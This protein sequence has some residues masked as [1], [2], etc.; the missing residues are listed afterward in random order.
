METDVANN[1]YTQ[2]I[3]RLSQVLELGETKLSGDSI[4]MCCPIHYENNPSFGI[5]AVNGAFHC[6]ACG[7]KGHISKFPYYLRSNI[8]AEETDSILDFEVTAKIDTVSYSAK[9]PGGEIGSIRNRLAD[10]SLSKYT[11]RELL[12]QIITGH[13]V[14]LSGAKNNS[15]WQGQ[16]VVMIDID[17]DCQATMDD[18]IEYATSVGLEPSFAYH[19]YT[20][21]EDVC[22]CRL[23]YV[24]KEPI[25]D[26]K[27]YLDILKR[28]IK[29]FKCYSVDP[30]CADLCRMFYGTMNTEVYVSNSV[31]YH[32][33]TAEQINEVESI[34]GTSSKSSCATS[35]NSEDNEFFDGKIF[36]HH[37]FGQYMIDNYYI[38]R[39]NGNQLHI[40][41]GRYLCE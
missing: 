33:F 15:E 14:S 32:R 37:I 41:K 26:K 23:A 20:S 16:Q 30:A 11:I 9:P 34:I 40:Y 29:I 21:T 4:Q 25:T 1:K 10:V 8:L 13:T 31:Y 22:R 6:F 18:I 36:L 19:T 38:I 2:P 27:M 7:V 17:N 3:L 35:N 28:L 24:F 12:E 39:L 5:N